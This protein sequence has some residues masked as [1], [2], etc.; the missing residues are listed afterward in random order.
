[1]HGRRVSSG[2]TNKFEVW[3]ANCLKRNSTEFLPICIS[4]TLVKGLTN[5]DIRAVNAA[6]KCIEIIEISLMTKQKDFKRHIP[7][8]K[9]NVNCCERF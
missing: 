4:M 3:L 9:G 2:N 5:S 1:M 6:Y 7:I 8:A